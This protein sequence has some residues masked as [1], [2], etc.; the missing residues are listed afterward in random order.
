M[1]TA[2]NIRLRRRWLIAAII[3]SL[4]MVGAGIVVVAATGEWI[5]WP[6]RSVS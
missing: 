2:Q 3:Y 5:A 4:V 1:T 6:A